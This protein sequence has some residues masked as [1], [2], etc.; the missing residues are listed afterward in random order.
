MVRG[1]ILEV[2][3][4]TLTVVAGPS[5]AGKTT[6]L[7][8]VAGLE[9]EVLGTIEVTGRDVGGIPAHR[10]GVALMFQQP[11]LFPNLSVLDNVAFG[12]QAAGVDRRRRRTEA[13]ELLEQVGLEDFAGRSPRGLS[14]GEQQR[15][16][17]ARALAVSP[18]LLLLDEPLSAVDPHRRGELRRL[19]ASLPRRRGITTLYVTHDREEAAELGDRIAVMLEGRIVQ[20]DPPEELFERPASP[21]VARFFGSRNVFGGSVRSGRLRLAG[22]WVEV[23]GPDGSGTFTI[24]PE[25]VRFE[26]GAALRLRVEEARYAGTHTRVALRGRDLRLEAH[27]VD[28]SAPVPGT[29]VGVVLPRDR[30]WRFPEPAAPLDAEATP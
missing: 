24:R 11:R 6:L 14:G 3:A 12:L 27:V 17:L 28:G 25:L 19:M 22:K 21:A 1:V 9:R 4:A 23:P 26:Q 2:P 13:M 5:G 30:I 10:R 8:A 16:A 29:E 15:V 20:H 18:E 7:R